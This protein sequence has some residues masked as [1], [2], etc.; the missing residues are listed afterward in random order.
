MRLSTYSKKNAKPIA[1]IM[2]AKAPTIRL[3]R[4]RGAM[5]ACGDGTVDAPM[6]SAFGTALRA[7]LALNEQFARASG[8]DEGPSLRIGLHLGDD[9]DA[10][11]QLDHVA[12]VVAGDVGDAADL[13]FPP[14]QRVVELGHVVE[15]DRVD[16]HDAAAVQGPKCVGDDASDRCGGDRGVEQG[17]WAIVEPA[18]PHRSE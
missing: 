13:A 9:G 5:A 8:E 6:P 3:T 18:R 7:A 15:V 10:R 4:F 11:G 16:R 14:E 1:R 12:H 17:W 2:P